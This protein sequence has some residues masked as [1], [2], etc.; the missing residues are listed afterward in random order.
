I[1][2]D[3]PVN[4]G[5]GTARVRRENKGRGGKTVTTIQGLLLTTDELKKLTADLKRRCGCGGSLKEGTIEIQGN[6]VDVI[7]E[8]LRK[9]GFKAVQAGG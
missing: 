3:E 1:C 8:E 9:R 4:T 7:I 2:K 5:D 6:Q